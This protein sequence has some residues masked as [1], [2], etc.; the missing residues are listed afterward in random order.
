MGGFKAS[1][2]GRE[3]GREGLDS[4]VETRSIGL[5]SAVA[6]MLEAAVTQARN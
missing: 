2:I 1:G 6:D 3:Q 4:Y 5:P